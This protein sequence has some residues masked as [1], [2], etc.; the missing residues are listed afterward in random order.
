MTDTSAADRKKANEGSWGIPLIL[1]IPSMLIH[2]LL[3]MSTPWLVAAWA[4]WGLSALFT[5]VGWISVMRHG[6]SDSKTWST[7]ALLHVVL[8][9]QAVT[10]LR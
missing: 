8:T 4:L 9:V 5:V 7:C 2:Y 3:N 10:L 1:L 6:V